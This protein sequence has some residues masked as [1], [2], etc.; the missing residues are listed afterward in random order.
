MFDESDIDTPTLGDEVQDQV[1][2]VF[3]FRNVEH[4][5]EERSYE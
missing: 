2:E 1:A 5:P 4:L 3:H